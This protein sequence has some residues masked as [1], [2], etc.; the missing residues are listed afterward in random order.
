MRNL[1]NHPPMIKKND[2]KLL[3]LAA[4]AMSLGWGIRGDYG[5]EAGAMIPGALLAL[6]ACVTSG[7]QDWLRRASL[8]ALSGAVGWAFGGQMS[9]GVVI[10]YTAGSSFRDVFYGYACLF[11]IG[12][13]WGCIGAG[14]LA[15]SMTRE[16]SYLATFARPLCIV[17]LV[18]MALTYSG[19]RERL[20]TRW[21]FN[22]TDWIAA[23]S[24]LITV[25]V[26]YMA[27]PRHRPA[28]KLIAILAAGWLAGL[29]VLNGALGLR[30]T[31]PRSDN[32]AGCAGL[33]VAL[34]AYLVWTQNRA[35]LML[36]LY[37]LLAG[38]IGFAV[39]DFVQMI[40]RAQWGP[41]GRF[42]SLQGLDYWKW[43][44]LLFGLIMGFGVALGLRRFVN[45]NLQ[46]PPEDSNCGA[47]RCVSLAVL[48]IVMPWENVVKNVRGWTRSE[49]I[50]EGLFHLSPQGWILI[51]ALLLTLLVVI[52][53]VKY[54]RSGLPLVP[55]DQ[56]GKAQ[57]LFLAVAWLF[58]LADF[59]QMLPALKSRSVLAVQ[60]KFWLLAIACSFI[61]ILIDPQ[62][63][64]QPAE[65][66]SASDSRWLPGW[67]YWVV[68]ILVPL[69][70]W[71]LAKGTLG[72]H[73]E[74]LPGSQIRFG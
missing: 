70:L 51:V 55:V 52:A 42:A 31:P 61:V 47:L 37:G 66:I 49:T 73:S 7:R 18:W 3:V 5:H 21:S 1:S 54:Q 53:I 69:L 35:A 28:C 13:M 65:G 33:S 23:L 40:G 63:V 2:F 19:I 48:F 46:S 68:W 26:V 72:M 24:A 15:L 36:A 74:P 25:A 29:I 58:T 56:L 12:A 57:L 34:L 17:Y 27:S 71:A 67:R 14:V 59:A 38:G 16:G 64:N 45:L 8:V 22:D 43:M 30:M 9:Y 39:G 20:A 62:T 10:G 11:A 6:A 32:W 44:E 41:I 4:L 60:A 50:S